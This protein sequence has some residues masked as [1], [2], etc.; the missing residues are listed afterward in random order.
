MDEILRHELVHKM[1]NEPQG[2]VK[3]CT[4]GLCGN[5]ATQFDI[6]V[7]CLA[8]ILRM[9]GNLSRCEISTDPLKVE[10]ETPSQGLRL[11]SS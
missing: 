6:K 2:C 5:H 7:V 4:G 1:C 11:L 3:C 9:P 10:T 8:S